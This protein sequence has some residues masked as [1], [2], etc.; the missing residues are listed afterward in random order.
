MAIFNPATSDSLTRKEWALAADLLVES[1]NETYFAQANLMGDSENDMVRVFT[2]L[3]K[4][5]GDRLDYQL[6]MQLTGAGATEGQALV[7][8]E[9]AQ[10]YLNDQLYINELRHAVKVPGKA[11]IARQ[12]TNIDQYEDAKPSLQDWFS[13]RFDTWAANQ[14]AAYTPQTDTKYTGL[15]AVASIDSNHVVRPGAITTDEGLGSSNIFTLDL[16][17]KALNKART[18][19]YNP[20]RP[21]KIGG[22]S[23]FV[24]FIHPN[25][26]YNMVTSTTTGGWLDVQ[27][28]II[29]GGALAESGLLNGA[30]GVYK[31][32]IIHSW[33]RIP[34]GVN[35][36]TSTSSVSNTRRAVFAGAGAL[37]LAFGNATPDM[38]EN[39]VPVSFEEEKQD[40]GKEVGIAGG[41]IGG[42]KACTFPIGGTTTSF[43]RIIIPTYA[44]AP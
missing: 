37:A 10:T 6:R 38:G 36:S 5:K 15:N 18:L 11:S 14:L 26:E 12:R 39:G 27:K 3:K 32:V 16:I 34:L 40:Y 22:K 24:C 17:D 4:G 30:L 25:Q 31:N 43:G 2:N 20:L 44:A 33:S 29:N 8:A 42:M 23:Y 19:T 13:V 1:L 9:E 28:A 35:S 41:L 21:I 7:G